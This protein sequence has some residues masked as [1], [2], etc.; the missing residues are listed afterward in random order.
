MEFPKLFRL[1][2]MK[3]EVVEAFSLTYSF[4]EVKWEDFFSVPL[5]ERE[6]NIL[7]CL[8]LLV[9]STFLVP[10][11]EDRLIWIHDNNGLFSVK[12]LSAFLINDGGRE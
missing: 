9:G 6:V 8:K 2:K 10:E 7:S 11:M 12:K 3:K 1:A 4:S 5:L